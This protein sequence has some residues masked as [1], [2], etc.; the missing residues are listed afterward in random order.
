MP[1][2][3]LMQLVTNKNLSSTKYN[4]FPWI[5]YLLSLFWPGFHRRTKPSCTLIDDHSNK[6]SALSVF[7]TT[8]FDSGWRLQ[9]HIE[10]ECRNI[11]FK[12]L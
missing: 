7:I 10:L 5:V 1:S 3:N 2:F 6:P 12:K 11:K 8:T 9:L 4:D